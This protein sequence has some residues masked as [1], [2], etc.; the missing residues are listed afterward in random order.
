MIEKTR[1]YK[2]QVKIKVV[3]TPEAESFGDA[4]RDIA[5]MDVIGQDDF[6]VV[7]GDIITNINIHEALKMHYYI[8][9]EENKKDNQ[10]TEKSRKINTIMTK[11][12][13]KMSYTNPLRDPNNEVTLLID[14]Q[15]KEILRYQ[16]QENKKEA[17]SMQLHINDDH[18]PIVKSY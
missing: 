2:K 3:S 17:K 13:L 15:T 1:E 7:R 16:S 6:I 5:S 9:K 14:K 11:L 8:K 10:D 4:L 12:F 18:T